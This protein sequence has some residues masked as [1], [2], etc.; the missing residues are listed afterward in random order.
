[1][2]PSLPSELWRWPARALRDAVRAGQVSVTEVVQEHLDRCAEV[3][4]ALNALVEV[5]AG[6]A[7]DRAQQLDRDRRTRDAGPLVGVP[8]AVKDNTDQAGHVTSFGIAAGAGNVAEEDAAVVAALRAAGAV[9]VGRSNLPAFSLRW[10]SENAVHGRTLNPWSPERTPGGSSGGAAAAVA[11]GMVPLAQGNDL[12]GSIRYPAA[13]CGVAGLRPTR[14]RISKW[15]RPSDFNGPASPTGDL[16]AVEGPIARHVAD[17]RLA[18]EPMS[19]P[20]LRDPSAVPVPYRDEPPLAAGAVVGVVAQLEGVPTAPAHRQALEQAVG[21]LAEA[22]YRVEEV[23]APELAEAHRLALLLCVED[24]RT[25]L[26][27]LLQLGDEQ[28]RRA[29]ENYFT[30]AAELWGSHPTLD[31][32]IQGHVRRNDLVRRIQHR[33]QDLPLLLTPVSAEPAPEHGADCGPFGRARALLH[34]QWPLTSVACLGLP[35]ASVPTGLV[36]GMPV[37]VQVVGGRFRE[38][39]VLD[40]AQAIEDRAGVVTPIDPVRG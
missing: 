29:L 24:L 39:W 32:Y 9:F 27:D 6:E 23:E 7:L 31:T 13:M 40:A 19:A 37:A 22:G 38:S 26:T 1:M 3:N 35:G 14:G 30:A 20:D 2:P 8:V 21:W 12:L 4:G 17:L 15:A 18:L 36:D 28:L 33:F 25:I 10:F 5:S 11:A 34:D 16:L